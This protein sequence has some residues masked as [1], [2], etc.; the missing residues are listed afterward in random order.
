MKAFTRLLHF[1][2]LLAG[3][4]VAGGQVFVLA[5]I[6][7]VKRGLSD[8]ESVRVHRAMLDALPDRYLL[9]S[10]IISTIAAALTLLVQRRRRRLATLFTLLG[11]L[12]GMGVV[13][14]SEKFNK[15]T[16]RLLRGWAGDAPLAGYPALRDR[17]DA[18]HAARTACGVLALVWYIAASLVPDALGDAGEPSREGA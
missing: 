15:P 4:I 3:A 7:P 1:V 9:P 5:V 18:V 16:N 10:H 11:L 12:S 6:V 14:T 17:W 8:G 13:I 2:N